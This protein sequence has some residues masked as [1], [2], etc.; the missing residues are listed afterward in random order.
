MWHK[1]ISLFSRENNGCPKDYSAQ[2]L[3][4]QILEYVMLHGKRDFADVIKVKGL[5]I[6]EVILEYTAETKLIT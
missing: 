2:T 4:S 6:G 3:N 1:T 5:K